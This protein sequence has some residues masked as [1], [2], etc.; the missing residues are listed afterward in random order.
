MA[1]SAGCSTRSRKQMLEH[2]VCFP[3]GVAGVAAAC[4]WAVPSGRC[5]GR[6]QIALPWAWFL[7]KHDSRSVLSLSLGRQTPPQ[8]IQIIHAALPW[9]SWSA[10]CSRYR[11][12]A[13]WTVSESLSFSK[14]YPASPILLI[15]FIG[16]ARHDEQ[17]P[18]SLLCLLMI[19]KTACDARKRRIAKDFQHFLCN[20]QQQ[21]DSDTC[22]MFI[23]RN[24]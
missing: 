14:R 1:V 2:H 15:L 20:A 13:S 21:R 23:A 12:C 5:R 17:G 24:S 8:M 11:C 10:L 6:F 4:L 7:R 16:L 22:D 3:I 9:T 19:F 18:C